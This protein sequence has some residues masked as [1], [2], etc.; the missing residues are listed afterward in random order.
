M[1]DLNLGPD[2]KPNQRF[3]YDRGRPRA[4]FQPHPAGSNVPRRNDARLIMERV[5]RNEPPVCPKAT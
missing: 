1:L 4:T 3:R 5:R 2:D